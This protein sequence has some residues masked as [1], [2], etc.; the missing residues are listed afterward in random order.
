MIQSVLVI[1]GSSGIGLALAQYYAAKSAKISII[2]RQPA[3]EE[4]AW[5]WF[6]DSLQSDEHSAQVV[7]QALVQQ[8]ELIFICNGVLHDDNAMPE[9]T[10][11]QLDNEIM[12]RR[13]YTNVAVPAR[14]LQLLLPYL[15]KKTAVKVVVLSAKVGSIADNALGGWYSYRISKAA[16]NMLVKNVSIEV[17]RLNASAT[18]ISVHPGTTDTLLSAPFQTN[19]PDGQLQTA[20]STAIRLAQVVQAAQPEQSGALFNWDGSIL[21]F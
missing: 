10:I 14:Y 13:F 12:M 1:G 3:S 6:E 8:P 4:N 2:S 20:G 19:L 16:L 15:N 5:H 11:R 9:K 21:P 7:Q 17:R 18:I